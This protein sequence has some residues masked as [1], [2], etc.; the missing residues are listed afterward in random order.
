VLFNG[1]Y[2]QDGNPLPDITIR[3]V[4]CR[5]VFP[6]DA[7]CLCP[8]LLLVAAAI[9][10]TSTLNSGREKPDTINSVDAGGSGWS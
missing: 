4:D 7:G 3:K 5:H 6:E 9:T 1:S 10:S 8:S 2:R